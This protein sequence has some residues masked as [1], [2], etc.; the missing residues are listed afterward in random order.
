MATR[1]KAPTLRA[2]P[3]SKNDCAEYIRT[4]GD[5]HREF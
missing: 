1:L 3:Q 4:V 2:V 5:L